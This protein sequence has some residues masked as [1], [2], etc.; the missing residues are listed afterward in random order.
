[1]TVMS[2]AEATQDHDR[3]DGLYGG[4]ELTMVEQSGLAAEL[5]VVKQLAVEAA[6]VARARPAR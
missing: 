5:E 3:P 6:A 1:M 4:K 2:Y